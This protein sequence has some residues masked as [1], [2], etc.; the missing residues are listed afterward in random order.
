MTKLEDIKREGDGNLL[1]DAIESMPEKLG[2]YKMRHFWGEK[3]LPWLR[4]E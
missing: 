1:A 4:A 2:M 3:V